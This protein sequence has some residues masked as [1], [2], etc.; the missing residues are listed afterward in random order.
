[1][2]SSHSPF[3]S[4]TIQ[5]V[6]EELGFTGDTAG[7]VQSKGDISLA[8]QHAGFITRGLPLVVNLETALWNTDDGTVP[9]RGVFSTVE[10]VQAV[11]RELGVRIVSIANNHTGDAG[12]EHFRAM[13]GLLTNAG[14]Q[15]VGGTRD[16]PSVCRVIL[17][18]GRRV[19]ILAWAWNAT[20]TTHPLI[21]HSWNPLDLRTL[22]EAERPNCDFLVALVH[23]GY[24]FMRYPLPA[25]R[26]WGRTLIDAGV[27]VV[28]G[29]H[30]HVIQGYERHRH[31]LIAY[32][33]GNFFFPRSRFTS[34]HP[35]DA[36]IGALL[37]LRFNSWPNLDFEFSGVENTDLGGHPRAID[38][39]QLIEKLSDPLR[40]EID[41]Y[42][43]WYRQQHPK[44]YL[45]I[46]DGSASD[47]WR[48]RGWWAVNEGIRLL[49]RLGVKDRMKTTLR[50]VNRGK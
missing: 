30:P 20:G 46:F 28:V 25:Q 42:A 50:N 21:N 24:E 17:A 18:S 35:S 23:W 12:A 40:M 38:I 41:E 43:E 2:R 10:D 8:L 16:V 9:V 37:R 31:G 48:R 19:S 27:D 26:R 22:I 29:A 47:R 15:V 45:P 14:V 13:H 1:M 7:T 11:C 39:G 6:G 5:V 33:L 44:W 34:Y 32:S 4:S 49:D 3:G 36:S